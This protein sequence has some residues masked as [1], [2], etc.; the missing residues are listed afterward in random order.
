MLR[1]VPILVAVA[2]YVYGIIDCARAP[3]TPARISKPVW[4]AL[5]I[6]VPVLGALIWIY[7]SHRPAARTTG[8]VAPDDD[9]EFLARLEARN[10]RRAYEAKKRAEEDGTEKNTLKKD[11][12]DPDEPQGGLYA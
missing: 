7:F 4:L 8:P 2:I 1:L 5:V 6:L 11:A 3:Q 12:E 9:P 10:R